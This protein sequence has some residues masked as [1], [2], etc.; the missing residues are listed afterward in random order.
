MVRRSKARE[1]ALQML[2]KLDVNSDIDADTL[3][4]QIRHE[5]H[6]DEAVERF[7][8]QL[9]A[10][11]RESRRMIDQKIEEVAENWSLT[12]MAIT[13]RNA[14]RLGAFELLLTDVPHRVAIDEAIEM[15]RLFGPERRAA[16][17]NPE[18]ES[19]D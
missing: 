12:R 13:D 11:V 19:A 4:A 5:L 9:V 7:C 3:R 15:A 1:V 14:I 17:K 2:Y 10:G 18:G 8:W 6:E 16:R